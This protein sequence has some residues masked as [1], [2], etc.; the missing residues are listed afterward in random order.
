VSAFETAITAAIDAAKWPTVVE[1][2]RS[3]L[4][5]SEFTTID[6][7]FCAAFKTTNN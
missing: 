5:T 7:A 4:K 6:K 2:L 3:T 1:T